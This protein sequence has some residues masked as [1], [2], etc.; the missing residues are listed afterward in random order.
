MRGTAVGREY[1]RHYSAQQHSEPRV[2]PQSNVAF[3][4]FSTNFQANGERMIWSA[5]YDHRPDLI[6]GGSSGAA[7]L[8]DLFW[9]PTSEVVAYYKAR[10][11]LS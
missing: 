8:Y 2:P 1:K 11:S 6:S 4:S 7:G 5:G 10:A 9:L 3:R